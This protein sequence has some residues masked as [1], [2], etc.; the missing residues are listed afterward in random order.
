M[1]PAA[2]GRAIV[3][4]QAWLAAHGDVSEVAKTLRVHPQ[5]VRYRLSGLRGVLGDG[6]LDDPIVRLELALALQAATA[7]SARSPGAG[8][9]AST[10]HGSDASD[11][12]PPGSA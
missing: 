8:G 10:S 5:T 9:D 2:R 6:A 4:L 1:T 3:T 7:L 11:E 12:P